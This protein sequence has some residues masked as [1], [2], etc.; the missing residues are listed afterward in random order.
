M[1][2]LYEIIFKNFLT[3]SLIPII[4]VEIFLIGTIFVLSLSQ[5]HQS[6]EEL[7]KIVLSSYKYV[8]DEK[9]EDI[10]NLFLSII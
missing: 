7:E 8:L 6:E 3:A 10:H 4:V 9:S 1:K 5:N 2:N